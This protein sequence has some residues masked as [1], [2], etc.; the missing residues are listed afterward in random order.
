MVRQNHNI[1]SDRLQQVLH[2]NFA[3]TRCLAQRSSKLGRQG[4]V[5]S[6]ERL[7]Y[8]G[9]LAERPWV[10][11]KSFASVQEILARVDPGESDPKLTRRVPVGV[12]APLLRDL[13]EETASKWAWFLWE[14]RRKSAGGW[15]YSNVPLR[16][17]VW[18]ARAFA[19]DH[20]TEP[21]VVFD[22][23]LQGFVVFDPDEKK[24]LGRFDF[25]QN[26]IKA[27]SRFP[28]S[29]PRFPE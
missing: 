2:E 3:T 16:T 14:Q 25:D 20:P 10:A 9:S 19:V 11:W 15:F 24:V 5:S 13:D 7:V 21:C 23:G 1:P 4:S 17:R 27:K 18:L 6:I 28:F 29:A 12:L 8:F 26:R 22:G